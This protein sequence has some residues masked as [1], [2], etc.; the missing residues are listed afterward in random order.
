M[1]AEPRH[2]SLDFRDFREYPTLSPE[3][4][5]ARVMACITKSEDWKPVGEPLV[6]VGVSLVEKT[7]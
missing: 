3:V 7:C 5:A 1:T 2:A 6:K 4:W